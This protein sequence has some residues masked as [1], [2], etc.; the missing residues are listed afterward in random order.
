MQRASAVWHLSIGAPASILMKIVSKSSLSALLVLGFFLAFGV[1]AFGQVDL[2]RQTT[3]ITYP[4]DETV[5]V[6]FRGTTRFPRL[7][8]EARISRTKKNGTEIDLSISKMPRPFE[9]GAGYATYVLWAVSPEGQIDNLGEVKRRGLLEFDSRISVTTRLQ[10]FAL[11]VTAE[12]HFLVR[13]PSQAIMLENLSPSAR[14][15]KS[16]VTTRAVQYFGNISDYFKDARTPEIAEADYSRTPSAILQAIQAVALARFAGAERDAPEE[17]EEAA[18][19]LAAAEEARKSEKSESD[20]DVIA[21]NAVSAAVKAEGVA[22]LR[23]EARNQRNE[24]T[25][26][27]EEIRKAEDRLSGATRD[28]EALRA[29]AARETRARELAERDVLNLTNQIKD[30]K[31]ENARLRD[32]LTKSKIENESLK[33]KI[34]VLEKERAELQERLDAGARADRAK[35]AI[36]SLAKELRKFGNVAEDGTKIVITFNDAIWS[37]G[38]ALTSVAANQIAGI[39]QTLAV[40]TDFKIK[41]ESHTDDRGTP[42]ELAAV[43]NQRAL[44]VAAKFEEGGVTKD[45]VEAEGVGALS[46][47]VDNSTQMNRSKNRRLY[48][49][50]LPR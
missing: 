11:I 39:A 47:L 35:S 40:N 3:A 25:K 1:T 18:R 15:G 19:L 42:E 5:D 32:D 20:V 45:R 13:R 23:A 43:S 49:F 4:Q 34:A 44:A 16:L 30:L 48:I 27:D 41:I 38:S 12:P 36:P 28:L 10:T 22:V 6:Q 14:S 8:G 7:K 9:L 26:Q 37:S 31:D 17:F 24:K 33:S 29:E 46:P 2:A 50:V 21:R